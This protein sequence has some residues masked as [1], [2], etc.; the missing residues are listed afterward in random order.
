[1]ACRCSMPWTMRSATCGRRSPGA[2]APQP[3]LMRGQDTGRRP[4]HRGAWHL[5]GALIPAVSCPMLWHHGGERASLAEETGAHMNQRR[6]PP[7]V[8][9]DVPVLHATGPCMKR[10]PPLIGGVLLHLALGTFS[11]WNVCVLPLAQTC[12]WSRQQTSCVFTMAVIATVA[13]FVLGGCMQD[14]RGHGS[15]FR[16]CR[17]AMRIVRSA[18]C[19]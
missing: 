17:T 6:T 18:Y 7:P 14:T 4:S 3:R 15:R 13:A 8:A 19:R 9:V 11:A 10:W 16:S 2:T 1:M 5:D 12:G